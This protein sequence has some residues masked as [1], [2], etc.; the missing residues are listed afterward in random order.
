MRTISNISKME[1]F[2]KLVIPSLV[3]LQ[4]DWLS[5]EMLFAT[6]IISMGLRFGMG[7]PSFLQMRTGVVERKN[8]VFLLKFW[9]YSDH[10]YITTLMRKWHV[11]GCIFSGIISWLWC[12]WYPPKIFCPWLSQDRSS[13]VLRRHPVIFSFC[14]SSA[15]KHVVINCLTIVLGAQLY[16]HLPHFCSPPSP[17][18]PAY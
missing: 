15:W 13:Q 9:R 16:N 2:G 18:D 12:P 3:P 1:A 4:A 17:K 6:D 8:E 10:T 5:L 11:G 7:P 14:F